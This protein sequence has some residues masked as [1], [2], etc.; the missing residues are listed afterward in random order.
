MI[1]VPLS[2]VLILGTQ[3]R[4][5][6]FTDM[7]NDFLADSYSVRYQVAGR[8][9]KQTSA[10]TYLAFSPFDEAIFFSFFYSLNAD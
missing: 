2:V 9:K 4:W 1:S 8:P 6:S 5:I 7:S 10:L 3:H